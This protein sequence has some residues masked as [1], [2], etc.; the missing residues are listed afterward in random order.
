M[1]GRRLFTINSIPWIDI[2]VYSDCIPEYDLEM[3]SLAP[4]VINELN[5]F[6]PVILRVMPP[7][8]DSEHVASMGC[9][10]ASAERKASIPRILRSFLFSS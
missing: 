5:R 1:K 10:E 9:V 6:I 4:L 3:E 2:L 7:C 8:A